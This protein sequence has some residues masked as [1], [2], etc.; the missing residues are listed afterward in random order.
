MGRSTHCWEP[1]MREFLEDAE[2][3]RQDGYGRAKAHVKRDLPKRFY[4]EAKVQRVDGGFAVGLDGRIPRTPGM[5]QVVVPEQEVAAA[6]AAEWQ[7]QDQFID[8]Q[9]MPLVRLV[10]SAVEASEES[11]P[12]LR[13]E[14]V[15]YA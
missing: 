15:K 2:T 13:E 8:P 14:I 3:H 10:N 6:M 4:T 12:A 9:T 5:K 1:L 11:M 7:A